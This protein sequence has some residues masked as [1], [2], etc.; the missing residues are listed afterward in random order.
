MTGVTTSHNDAQL[1]VAVS[2]VVGVYFGNP[3]TDY[4]TFFLGQMV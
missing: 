2:R 1:F 3:S 4:R